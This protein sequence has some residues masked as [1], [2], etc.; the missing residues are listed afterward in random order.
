PAHAEADGNTPV[1]ETNSPAATVQGN[2]NSPA[3]TG[4][5]DR[6]TLQKAAGGAA[7]FVRTAGV[8]IFGRVGTWF[9]ILTGLALIP[10]YAFY[11]LLEKERIS[12][13]WSNY[14]PVSDSKF[15]DELVF[16]IRSIN[17]Y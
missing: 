4:L 13:H 2:T 7:G 17:E 8:W 1:I 11:F 6:Q 10:V 5:L 9:E 3:L 15:K 12:T 16:V 14:L